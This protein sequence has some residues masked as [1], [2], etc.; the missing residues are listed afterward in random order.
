MAAYAI[1]RCK[2][3]AKMGNVAAS[4]KHAFRE[5]D[6]PNADASRTPDNEHMAA[7]ST[8]AAMGKLRDRLPEKR[9]KDAVLCVE[10]VMTASPE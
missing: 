10:Y 3:L 6:T 7:T 1:M 8:D 4:L 2:K 5:R 9:R